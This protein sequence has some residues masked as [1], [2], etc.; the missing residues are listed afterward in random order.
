MGHVWIWVFILQILEIVGDLVQVCS[1]S[2][3]LTS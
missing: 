3:H 1:V 2:Y